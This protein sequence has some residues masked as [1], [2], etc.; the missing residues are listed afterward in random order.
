M[1]EGEVP[2]AALKV[3]INALW[4]DHSAGLLLS[5]C[6]STFPRWSSSLLSV[7]LSSVFLSSAALCI[8]CVSAPF[9][10]HLSEFT[11]TPPPQFFFFF[12]WSLLP[13]CLPSF[14]TCEFPLFSLF[15]IMVP[16]RDDPRLYIEPFSQLHVS[17]CVRSIA[18][19]SSDGP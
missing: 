4:S 16:V 1:N 3:N 13:S 6:S 7:L 2:S 10:F 19:I 5:L 15:T 9:S 12:F 14:P 17:D 11:A 18:Q 8:I